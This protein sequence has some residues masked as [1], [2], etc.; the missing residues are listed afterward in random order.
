M[1]C[2]IKDDYVRVFSTKELL[3]SDMLISSIVIGVGDIE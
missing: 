1:D 2:N 3:I